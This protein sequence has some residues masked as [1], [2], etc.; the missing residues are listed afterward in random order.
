MTNA[1]PQGDRRSSDSDRLR[2]MLLLSCSDFEAFFGD[3]LSLD[4]ESYLRSYRNDWSWLYARILLE[5]GFQPVIG[6]RSIGTPAV[7]HTL[8]GIEV[9][10]LP[11]IFLWRYW[12]Q[13]RLLHRTFI[14]RYL[15]ELIASIGSLRRLRDG[16][17][18]VIYIQEYWQAYFDIATIFGTV[19]TVAGD[20][21]GRPERTLKWFKRLAF[22]RS[23]WVTSQ[24]QGELANAS[25][26]GAR[27]EL[28][29]NPIDTD[30]YCPDVL[31]DDRA[32]AP[33]T[34]VVV[35]RLTDHQKRISD[36]IRA[37]LYLPE[38]WSLQVYGTGPDQADLAGL[39]NTL[40]VAD[41]VTF[42]GFVADPVSLRDRYRSAGVVVMASAHE[43]R[44]LA[45]LEALSCG[46]AVVLSDIPVFQEMVRQCGNI[47]VLFRVGNP[48][49]L[50]LA[51]QEAYANRQEL[52]SRAQHAAV[53]YLGIP[54]FRSRLV[55]LL[56][57]AM[58]R[59]NKADH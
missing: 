22:R 6:I 18:D 54:P 11:T 40:G 44:S 58:Q 30:L 17:L 24:T 43:A 2:I 15:T 21:G 1:F 9:E 46:C 47:A 8:E 49:V 55:E 14:G 23:P 5:S 34:I 57:E 12:R 20:H 42:R 56:S 45:V 41:R 32:K 31:A 13:C 26:Y 53:T 28:L 50:A 10:Y 33:K 25:R 19:P 48:E 52:G 36:V 29:P 7:Y 37:L 16:T 38:D 27:A 59:R 4:R 3:V 39:A 35:A 51:V